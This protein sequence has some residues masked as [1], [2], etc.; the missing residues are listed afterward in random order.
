MQ[1]KKSVARVQMDIDLR[2]QLEQALQ[3]RCQVIADSWY[4]AVAQT[5]YVL[6]GAAEVRQR[7]ADL[8]KQAAALL[9][10]E[11]FDHNQAREIGAALA[12][13]HYLKPEALGRTIGILSSHFTDGLP[14]DHAAALQ[15][16]L[17]ALL[18][19]VAT[20]FV[21]QAS[22]TILAEQETV[23]AALVGELRATEKS[24]REAR[25]ELEI[26]VQERTAE[27]AQVNEELRLEIVERKQA[28]EA[29]QESRNTTRALL[30]APSDRVALVDTGGF[31]LDINEAMA[32]RY[33]KEAGDLIGTCG[34]YGLSPGELERVKPHFE[35]VLRS[36]KPVRF[37][38]ER[39][40]RWFDTV[41]YP[42]RDANGLVTKVAIFTRDI[43]ERKRMEEA[44]RES[45]ER[46]RSLVE[47]APDI[48]TTVDRAG[49]VLFVNRV[50]PG[51]ALTVD[52]LIGTDISDHALP[53]AQELTKRLIER[54]FVEGSSEYAEVPV[55]LSNGTMAWY[56]NRMGP[57]RQDGEV[58]ATMIL[59]R[60]I[61]EQRQV[62]DIKDN[63]IRD[64]SHELRTP[65]AKMQMSLDLLLEV[66][67][68][69]P[70][71][72]QKATKIAEMVFGNTQRS[73]QTVEAI[74][75]LSALE[76]GRIIYSKTRIAP[77]DL[78]REAV[79]DMQP[80]ALAK[81]LE[82]VAQVPNGLPAIEGDRDQLFR[83]L[84]NL[85][86]NAVKFSGQ[87]Q[88]VLSVR[89]D[90]PLVE[91]AVTDQGHGIHKE[92]LPKVFDRFY[93]EKPNIPGSGVGL[94]ICKTIVE[95]HGGRIWAKSPGRGQGTTLR[96]T[97]PVMAR[98][99]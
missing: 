82:L 54:V 48:V 17:A 51:S 43:T 49:R 95:A 27:L 90:G 84:V 78:I 15:P 88:I 19:G 89:E 91:F 66:L 68:K 50:V 61:T 37:E 5:G 98:K 1:Y 83:V 69:E 42:V 40:G 58:A 55:L 11:P 65:L 93:Q 52:D 12:Q 47:N 73:L 72:R 62:E 39:Q 38:T 96:F 94:P 10:T 21:G 53:E 31:F 32:R 29:L 81:G 45:Q 30:D 97:L 16:G 64:V 59:S 67:N 4:R 20:G 36:G 24:L 13:L 70:I 7:L 2:S 23:R 86:D 22:R 75:D 9:V 80:M 63:I 26:R 18:D 71:N 77:G 35:E 46:W 57:I 60:D 85:V 41:D 25:D 92:N 8:V 14:A 44:L 76:A 74:L 34:W 87:G 3:E 99:E 56:A 28:E 33:G 6:V 79:Q